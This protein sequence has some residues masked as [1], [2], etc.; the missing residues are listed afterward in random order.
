M[1][2]AIYPL[3]HYAFMTWCSVKKQHRDNFTFTFIIRMI[4]SR[5]EGVRL[6][7]HAVRSV[8]IR[9]AHTELQSETFSKRPPGKPC[10]K[11]DD[12]IKMN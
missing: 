10:Q 9:K 7:E 4:K 12:N 5:G 8:E 6:T 2:G 3:P 1:R 11:W